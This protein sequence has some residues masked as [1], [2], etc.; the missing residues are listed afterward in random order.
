MVFLICYISDTLKLGVIFLFVS[1]VCDVHRIVQV[2]HQSSIVSFWLGIFLELMLLC[3]NCYSSVHI[4]ICIPEVDRNF[5]PNTALNCY[6]RFSD[7]NPSRLYIILLEVCCWALFTRKGNVIIK[8]I[9]ITLDQNSFLIIMQSIWLWCSRFRL[10]HVHF[11]KGWCALNV[12]A[13]MRSLELVFCP[14]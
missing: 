14:M 6:M 11:H 3:W 7:F 5:P 13:S 4:N 1:S 12:F 9:K 10:C 2:Y 8:I